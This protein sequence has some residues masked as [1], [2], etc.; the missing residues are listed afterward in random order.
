MGEGY[1]INVIPNQSCSSTMLQCWTVCPGPSN[2]M[3]T[4]HNC[5][6]RMYVRV[7]QIL[8]MKNIS[9]QPVAWL[10]CDCPIHLYLF[11]S[12]A[13]KKRVILL[14]VG[15]QIEPCSANSYCVETYQGGIQPHKGAPELW[16]STGGEVIDSTVLHKEFPNEAPN[17]I[18]FSIIIIIIIVFINIITIISSSTLNISS[19]MKPQ[20]HPFRQSIWRPLS[21]LGGNSFIQNLPRALSSIC[22]FRHPALSLNLRWC[23]PQL[24]EQ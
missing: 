21:L 23:S 18:H 20:H 3:S 2:P 17:V 16:E 11:K 6:G 15:L 12:F 22:F 7:A 1:L 4:V 19:L 13:L 10:S 14:Q 24:S 8:L 5:P 9:I